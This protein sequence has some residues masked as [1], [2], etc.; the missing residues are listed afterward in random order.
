[1]SDSR[2]HAALPLGAGDGR[3]IHPRH[4]CHAVGPNEIFSEPFVLGWFGRFEGGLVNLVLRVT[5]RSRLT[6]SL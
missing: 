2:G 4:L 1:L 5:A 3:L 6:S